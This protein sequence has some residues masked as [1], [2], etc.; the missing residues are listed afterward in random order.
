MRTEVLEEVL[1]QIWG[2]NFL[3][4]VKDM[5]TDDFKVCNKNNFNIWMLIKRIATGNVY[6]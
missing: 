6:E 2:R 1:P 5:T 4:Y 3:F